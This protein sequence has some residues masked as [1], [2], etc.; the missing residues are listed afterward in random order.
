VADDWIGH[1]NAM[2]RYPP[3]RR[4]R[5]RAA[6]L[7]SAEQ[8]TTRIRSIRELIVSLRFHAFRCS[9]EFASAPEASDEDACPVLSNATRARRGQLIQDTVLQQHPVRVGATLHDITID[10]AAFGAFE[11]A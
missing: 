9:E 11:G 8:R 7:L 4:R 5:S 3:A 2:K 10:M 6:V 1:V